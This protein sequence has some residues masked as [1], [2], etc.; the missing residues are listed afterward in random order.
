M[1]ENNRRVQFK[2]GRCNLGVQADNSSLFPE[3]VPVTY[4]IDYDPALVLHRI[5]VGNRLAFVK[6]G[7]SFLDSVGSISALLG[8]SDHISLAWPR[9]YTGIA[10]ST[11][12]KQQTARLVPPSAVTSGCSQSRP[13]GKI[14]R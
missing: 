13:T 7:V 5:Y 9:V 12:G 14:Q 8:R 6:S 4:C 1:N 10:D 2:D 11:V 3:S